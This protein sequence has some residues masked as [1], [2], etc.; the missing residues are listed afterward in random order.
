[1]VNPYRSRKL[2]DALGQLAKTDKIDCRVLARFA[3]CGSACNID[4]LEGVIG[5]QN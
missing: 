1:V 5:V 2:A 4:P 3:G